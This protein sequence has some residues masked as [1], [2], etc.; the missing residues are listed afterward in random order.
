MHLYE[1]GLVL[2]AAVAG[3][4][5]LRARVADAAGTVMFAFLAFALG[6]FLLTPAAFTGYY[7]GALETRQLLA[8]GLTLGVIADAGGG[9]LDAAAA[10]QVVLDSAVHTPWEHLNFGQR[11]TDGCHIDKAREILIDGI[12]TQAATNLDV[13]REC[14][15]GGQ[16]WWTSPPTPRG[17]GCSERSWWLSGSWPWQRWCSSPRGLLCSPR[18]S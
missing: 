17:S 3:W 8:D 12:R 14:G 4:K 7:A 13:L 5:L 11:L 10:M 1:L 16:R 15:A 6:W 18:Y 9:G 2:L